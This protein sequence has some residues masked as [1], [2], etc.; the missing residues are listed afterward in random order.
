MYQGCSNTSNPPDW[1]YK[2]TSLVEV[3]LNPVHADRE[4]VNQ[5]EA[6]GMLGQHRREHAGDNVS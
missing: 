6:L 4:R 5:V 3:P 2:H 1:V